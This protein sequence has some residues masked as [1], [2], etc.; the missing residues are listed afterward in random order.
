MAIWITFNVYIKKRKFLYLINNTI[1]TLYRINNIE[2]NY[3]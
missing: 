3:K 2:P 1:G